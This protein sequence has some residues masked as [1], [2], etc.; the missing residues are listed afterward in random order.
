MIGAERIFMITWVD[1]DVGICVKGPLVWL[2]ALDP[3]LAMCD[4]RLW[5]QGVV[6]I[7]QMDF[8]SVNHQWEVHL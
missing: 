7:K 3:N 8:M 6:L 2:Q 1:V 4:C 5:I